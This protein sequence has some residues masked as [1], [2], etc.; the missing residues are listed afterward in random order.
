V[1]AAVA[2]ERVAIDSIYKSLATDLATVPSK[3]DVDV[4]SKR[5]QAGNSDVFSSKRAADALRSILTPIQLKL[6]PRGMLDGS[7]P[8]RPTR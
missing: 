1:N 2:H 6:V 4:V 7:G 3:Y 5:I 8:P